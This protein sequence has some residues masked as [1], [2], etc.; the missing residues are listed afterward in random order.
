MQ[1]QKQQSVTNGAV[2]EGQKHL[3]VDG[4]KPTATDSRV[5]MRCPLMGDQKRVIQWTQ[6]DIPILVSRENSEHYVI[7]EK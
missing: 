3:W 6:S 4:E 7:N 5:V 1:L 2:Y